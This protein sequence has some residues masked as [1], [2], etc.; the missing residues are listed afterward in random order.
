MQIEFLANG[1]GNVDRATPTVSVALFNYSYYIQIY[2]QNTG[3]IDLTISPLSELTSY[4]I[5]R[6]IG[7]QS[8]VFSPASRLVGFAGT[9]LSRRLRPLR[10]SRSDKVR[11]KALE[12]DYL[13][14][15]GVIGFYAD[16]DSLSVKTGIKTVDLFV[17]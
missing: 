12:Q 11:E 10:R 6:V 14:K 17:N 1:F 3:S 13:E 5:C 16:S 4:E 7:E 15:V 8:K 9:V 2:H